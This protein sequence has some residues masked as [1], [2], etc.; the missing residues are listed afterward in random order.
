MISYAESGDDDDDEDA[1]NPAQSSKT[2]G[3]AIKRRKTTQIDEEENFGE[4]DEDVL[5][6]GE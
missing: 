2:R 3:R 6:E 1:F 5:D 4:S